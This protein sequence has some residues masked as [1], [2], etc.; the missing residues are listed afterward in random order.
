MD[1]SDHDTESVGGPAQ[2]RELELL[3]ALAKDPETRQADLATR[4][5]VAVGTINWLLKRLS[6]KGFVKVRRIERWR[7]RYVLTPQGFARK[8]RLTKQYLWLSMHTYRIT[9]EKARCLLQE[10][11]KSNHSVVRLEGN[12]HDDLVDVCRLTCLEQA[13]GIVDG[14]DQQLARQVPALRVVDR[15]IVLVWPEEDAGA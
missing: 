10:V 11:K 4:L 3:E 12:P 2:P 8:A 1:E 6:V 9:R 15:E 14:K 5:G 13:V 7:W